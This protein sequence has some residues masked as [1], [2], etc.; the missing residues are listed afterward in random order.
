MEFPLPCD[1]FD[2]FEENL[3]E[4]RIS[5][6]SGLFTTLT[7][8]VTSLSQYLLR[9]Q[10]GAKEEV[11]NGLLKKTPLTLEG[12]KKYFQNPFFKMMSPTSGVSRW[13]KKALESDAWRRKAWLEAERISASE[14]RNNG[15][16]SLRDEKG[17]IGDLNTF[18]RP[19]E[20]KIGHGSTIDVS[21][22]HTNFYLSKP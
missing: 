19:I 9:E 22:S 2:C 11:V 13:R 6:G 14:S 12:S 20:T 18:F 16:E 3:V 15:L 7:I 1:L 5:V 8:Y 10:R 21:K 17:E 4:G